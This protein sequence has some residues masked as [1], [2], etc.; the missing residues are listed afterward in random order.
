MRSTPVLGS[1]VD[2]HEL[3]PAEEPKAR[4][5]TSL[6]PDPAR[7]DEGAPSAQVGDTGGAAARN[8]RER[9]E[10]A[11]EREPH[12]AAVGV[13][14]NEKVRVDCAERE[15]EAVTKDD[16]KASVAGN[17]DGS[18]ERVTERET[19]DRDDVAG[20]RR[21]RAEDNDRKT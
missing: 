21:R 17:R 10:R 15:V 18:I 5:R 1:H 6:H 20:H 4:R 16:M 13:A 2:D 3:G 12:L 9:D 11:D 7:D 19:S 8:C 14:G